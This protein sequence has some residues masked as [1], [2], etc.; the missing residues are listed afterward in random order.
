MAINAFLDNGYDSGQVFCSFFLNSPE[1]KLDCLKKLALQNEDLAKVT[2]GVKR[3]EDLAPLIANFIAN[4]RVSKQ[5]CLRIYAEQPKQ[6]LSFKTGTYTS[7][8]LSGTPNSL[9]TDFCEDVWHGPISQPEHTNA[10]YVRTMAIDRPYYETSNGTQQIKHSHI[11]WMITAEISPSY[12]ALSWNGFSHKE[13]LADRLSSDSQFPFWRYIP[14]FIEELSA[15]IG[16][17]YKDVNLHKLILMH[18]WDK[19]LG[20]QHTN[21][22]SHVWRH[23]RIRSEAAGVAVNAH[24]SGIAEIDIKGIQALSSQLAKSALKSLNMDEDASNVSVVEKAIIRTLIH[25]WGAKSYEF[26]L[27]GMQSESNNPEEQSTRKNIFRAHC[28]FGLTP[29]R[30]NQDSFQH[31]KCYAGY[32][33][34]SGT[35]RFLL[36]ALKEMKTGC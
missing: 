31:L 11:R 26:S 27:E 15:I 24:S 10:W 13:E 7:L 17:A 30:K 1:F 20:D 33:G 5:D 19:Y 32:G 6:W 18:L 23:R 3:K 12:I 4:D 16:G 35:L 25:E 28:Y 9:F 22:Y 29:G 14:N 34:T 2:K 8:P 21:S 36:S